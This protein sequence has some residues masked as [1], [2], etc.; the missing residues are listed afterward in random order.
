[1]VARRAEKVYNRVKRDF[2]SC[3]RKYERSE[4]GEYEREEESYIESGAQTA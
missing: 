3:I 1:M 2:I 4:A